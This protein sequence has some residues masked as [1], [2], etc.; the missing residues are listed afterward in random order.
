PLFG[1]SLTTVDG[2]DWRRRRHLM[3][4]MFTPQR[5]SAL[6]PEIVG[7]VNAVLH[8]GG[9]FAA[10]RR[11]FDLFAEMTELT[12]AIILRVLFGG[13]PDEETR[14]GGRAGTIVTEGV[15]R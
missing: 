15:E 12:R 6:V 3:R 8:P 5:M 14:S 1:E 7:A 10:P 4:P 2:K 11:P 9:E 13:L